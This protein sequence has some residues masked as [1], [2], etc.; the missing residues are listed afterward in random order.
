MANGVGDPTREPIAWT[1]KA[2]RGADT[3]RLDEAAERELAAVL[4]EVAALTVEGIDGCTQ[5]GVT[6]D[7]AGSGRAVTATGAQARTIDDAQ[8]RFG[9]GPCLTALR[10]DQIVSCEDLGADSRWPSVAAVAAAAGM[11]SV[12]SIP[13]HAQAGQVV[14]ALN[15]YGSHPRAFD[16]RSQ[17]AAAALVRQFS[18]ILR[19]LTRPAADTVR[20]DSWQPADL[21]QARAQALTEL[22]AAAEQ[23]SQVLRGDL[24]HALSR[25]GTL[26]IDARRCSRLI[27]DA[28]IFGAVELAANLGVPDEAIPE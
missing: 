18:I 16:A 6:W 11:G 19:Y 24:E 9:D 12:L 23:E 2:A 20:I 13:L 28:F 7:V 17:R 5:V 4:A 3:G 25:A 21:T 15:L 1:S 22:L 10:T 8:Y 27:E 26:A 14:G